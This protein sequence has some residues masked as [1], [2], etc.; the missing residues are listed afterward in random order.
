MP[1][2]QAV[3]ADEK[4]EKFSR[5]MLMLGT[6]FVVLDIILANLYAAPPPT[7]YTMYKLVAS[8]GAAGV[9]SGFPGS[10]LVK[11]NDKL[12]AGGAFGIFALVFYTYP[13]IGTNEYPKILNA[14]AFRVTRGNESET[15]FSIDNLTIYPCNEGDTLT[16]L[17]ISGRIK[18]GAIIGDSGPEGIEKGF[19]GL[20]IARYCIVKSIK[21]GAL[22]YRQENKDWTPL[23]EN[24]PIICPK[25]EIIEFDIN[26]NE[27]QNN[28]GQ[29]DVR[30]RCNS[31]VR[32]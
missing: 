10:F 4:P 17:K 14:E 25:R 5:L 29:Y 28:E 15:T 13:S 23:R 1:K 11:V 12:V 18:L 16:V 31:G 32:K 3:A 19:L 24:E 30:I 8:L 7:I 20:P 22:M 2:I 27:K 21:H 6:G 9:A 26:D